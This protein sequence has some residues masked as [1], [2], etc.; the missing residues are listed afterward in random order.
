M[1]D[2]LFSN[3]LHFLTYLSSP[4]A[5]F[6]WNQKRVDKLRWKV[7]RL[8]HRAERLWSASLR[9]LNR[10]VEAPTCTEKSVHVAY[11]NEGRFAI[12]SNH[13]SDNL[14]QLWPGGS[15]EFFFFVH[16]PHCDRKRSERKHPYKKE[17][18][19]GSGGIRT[20]A[21]GETGALIQRLRPLGHATC[22]GGLSLSVVLLFLIC[23]VFGV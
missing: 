4:S 6:I 13:C 3:V 22:T 5:N 17:K 7:H 23:L 12:T 2:W 20:H 19:D 16:N 10:R 1:K 21:P 8:H 15:E 18:S 9:M 11:S 14:K